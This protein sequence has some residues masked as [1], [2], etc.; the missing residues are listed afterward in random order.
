[1]THLPIF[2]LSLSE[3]LNPI[4]VQPQLLPSCFHPS[5]LTIEPSVNI[6]ISWETRLSLTQMVFG[7]SQF[8]RSLQKPTVPDTQP[9]CYPSGA[10]QGSFVGLLVF[11]PVHIQ[12][13]WNIKSFKDSFCDT[14]YSEG[15]NK[16][17]PIAVS[18]SLSQRAI[19]WIW[20]KHEDDKW[21]TMLVYGQAFPFN[22][23][24]SF[25]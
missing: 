23:E 1:M 11:N 16:Y 6:K 21:W 3:Y 15:W 20:W 4:C 17:Q 10:P 13:L 19:I 14:N 22:I 12:S 9:I 7:V 8:R 25:K 24:I 5:V 2:F 18:L